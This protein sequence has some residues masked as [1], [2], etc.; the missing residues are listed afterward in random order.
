MNPSILTTPTQYATMPRGL[1]GSPTPVPM[2][3]GMTWIHPEAL[4]WRARVVTN[5]G[6]VSSATLAAVSEFC[7]R[8][9][10]AGIRD[11]FYRLNLFCGDSIA[12]VMVPLYRSTSF[13]GAVLGNAVETNN[14]PYVAA[15]YTETGTNGGLQH[16]FG[17]SLGTGLTASICPQFQTLHF[18][19]SAVSSSGHRPIASVLTVGS[20]ERI[21][22]FHSSVPGGFQQLSVSLG[23]TSGGINYQPS[24]ATPTNRRMIASR[25][26]SARMDLYRDNV[27]VASD[28]TERTPTS[29]G[30]T[31]IGM[32]GTVSFGAAGG[33]SR[34]YSFGAAMNATQVAAYDAAL[35]AF[36]TA[37]G[38]V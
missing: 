17:K 10:L 38:R 26:S 12:A 22:V 31:Q 30:N 32:L 19:Y 3:H 2:P 33:R 35:S 37:M 8:I 25:T 18:A 6:R 20:T 1:L 36:L 16:F 29:G 27:I 5:G 7:L 34:F 21:D 11:R 9:E 24:A 4:D 23:Q 28:T 13:G 15:D 14:G